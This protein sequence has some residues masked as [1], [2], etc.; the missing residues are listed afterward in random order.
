MSSSIGAGAFASDQPIVLRE[1]G[2]D[3]LALSLTV[4]A[5]IASVIVHFTLN[6]AAQTQLEFE[7]YQLYSGLVSIV[8]PPLYYAAH[9]IEIVLILAA[10]LSAMVNTDTRSIERGYLGRLAL[11]TAAAMLMA[12][13][14]YTSSDWLST[15]LV[16]NTGPFPFF[17]SVLVFV[18]ARRS[19]WPALDKLITFL[20]ALYSVKALIGIAGMRSLGRDEA[21]LNL[22]GDLNA[23][24]W[25]AAWMALKDYPA[26]S[27]ARRFRFAPILVYAVGSLFTQTRLNI[28]MLAGLLLVYTYLQKKRRAPQAAVWITGI[29]LAVWLTLFALAFMQDSRLIQNLQ[30][31]ADAFTKR[32]DEDT[33]S[34]QLMWFFRDVKPSELILGR[35]SFATWQWFPTIWSGTDVGYLSLLFYGGLPLLVTY[36]ITHMTPGFAV[37]SSKYPTW[38]LPA[39]GIVALWSLRMFSSSYPFTGIDYYPILLCVG[40][41]ISREPAVEHPWSRRH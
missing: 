3:R 26:D 18:G 15:R 33:R 20:A 4:L 30:H 39:A 22:G 6:K 14:G 11:L 27:L 19:N 31:A 37:I 13:R 36:V 23:L 10:G 9:T 38:Q 7:P 5:M 1:E 12:V 24:Y 40:A 41:C 21:I 34:G 2:P 25:P 16:D 17:I 29:M 8:K 35:G 32:L 28:V